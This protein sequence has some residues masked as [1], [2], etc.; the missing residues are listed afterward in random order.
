MNRLLL[1]SLAIVVTQAFGATNGIHPEVQLLDDQGVPVVV[2]NNPMSATETC[3]D[4][5]DGAF[6][7]AN[8]DHSPHIAS[9]CLICHSDGYT[10]EDFINARETE[11]SKWSA[12]A[13]LANKSLAY[14]DDTGWHW[15]RDALG[16]EGELEA[17]ELGVKSAD[18]ESCGQCHGIVYNS[19]EPL[20]VDPDAD[21]GRLTRN[22]GVIYSGQKLSNSG[23]NISHKDDALRSFDVHAERLLECTDC[24][25][26][27][28]NPLHGGAHGEKLDHLAH[29][30]RL[31][32][33]SEFLERPDHNLV[34]GAAGAGGGCKGCHTPE[35]SHSWLDET[36]L[37]MDVLACQSCH[38]T[39]LYGPAQ[40]FKDDSVR[41]SNGQAIV[42]WRSMSSSIDL[43]KGFQ[44]V[45]LQRPEDGKFAPY[46][47]SMTRYWRDGADNKAVTTDIVDQA[48]KQ[49]G[50]AG[51]EA[52]Q[53]L[54][55]A[56]LQK[57]Q[58][59]L[60]ALGVKQPEIATLV[61]TTAINHGVS[62]DDFA[63][64]ECEACHTEQGRMQAS[65]PLAPV[66]PGYV[67]PASLT[68][69]GKP[70]MAMNQDSDNMLYVSSGVTGDYEL[71][72]YLTLQVSGLF[73]ALFGLFGWL[74]IK[75]NKR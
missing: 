16:E 37:H 15:Q 25:R 36:E 64:S 65:L 23:M 28:N 69:D 17:S 56:D 6:I 50:L 68:A 7:N 2:S 12:M 20:V 42:Q 26:A 52:G 61:E 14:Q 67:P 4:C 47:V 30:P 39:D 1:A 55:E 35:E 51:V 21:I 63:L 72:S 41:D 29:D 27:A 58:D 18:S 22:E 48:W 53:Y 19:S 74:W 31:P 13:G 60:L 44:P 49:S 43:N 46:N 3:T 38:I 8:H 11:H 70:V 33:I 66:H 9:N 75:R 73:G 45:L 24:H 10:A 59:S 40:Q 71:N 54:N 5:H 34:I 57:L 32:N 62:R